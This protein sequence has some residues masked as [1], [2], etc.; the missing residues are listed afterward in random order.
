MNFVIMFNITN[1]YNH[2]NL[3]EETYI[4]YLRIYLEIYNLFIMFDSDYIRLLIAFLFLFRSFIIITKLQFP[5][6]V[7]IIFKDYYLK[8]II[9]MTFNC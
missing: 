4:Y 2:N 7:K 3:T 5:R 9:F 6:F 1:I 8:C